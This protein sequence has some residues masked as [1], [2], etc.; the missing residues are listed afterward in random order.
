MIPFHVQFRHV[1]AS[2]ALE[3][4]IQRKVEA[5]WKAC[6]EIMDCRVL[7]ERSSTRQVHANPF[8]VRITAS[9]PHGDPL[10][11]SHHHPHHPELKNARAAI[12]DAF[13]TMHRVADDYRD[14]LH[15]EVKP[16]RQAQR[17]TVSFLAP[18]AE[19]GRIRT[20]E[21]REVYFHRHSL[22]TGEF[23][24]LKPGTPVRFDEEMGEEGPQAVFVKAD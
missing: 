1:P 20:P 11:V 21:G 16:R 17:G 19:S 9:V 2:P 23:D 7:V 13:D 24:E 10:V 5:L 6:P 15:R 14:K 18:D 8:H 4:T 3:Q 12:E 22:K